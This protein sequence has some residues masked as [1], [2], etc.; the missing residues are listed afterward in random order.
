M[1]PYRKVPGD[2]MAQCL[3]Y[4]GWEGQPLSCPPTSLP[5]V[6][7]GLIK[8]LPGVLG[9]PADGSQTHI[10]GPSLLVA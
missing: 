10:Q 3:P 9:P 4:T 5:D 2:S 1:T 8:V 6:E 7:G